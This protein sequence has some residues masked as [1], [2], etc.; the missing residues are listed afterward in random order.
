MMKKAL[1][2]FFWFLFMMQPQ[3]SFAQDIATCSE[4]KGYSY[5]ANR[6]MAHKKSVGWTE[7]E[8]TGGQ[9][10]FRVNNDGKLDIL[11]SGI[12]GVSSAIEEGANIV[13][14]TISDDAATVVTVYPNQ[15]TETYVFQVLK[16][17][18]YQAMWTQAKAETPLPKITALISECSFLDL[19]VLKK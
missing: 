5:F 15:L 2:L 1:Y 11:T 8:I 13:L 10:T 12:L 16:N 4:A 7:D 19:E 17:G 6:A 14:A 9:F 3:K 18:S